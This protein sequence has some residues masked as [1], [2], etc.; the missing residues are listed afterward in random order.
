MKSY[1]SFLSVLR[2]LHGLDFSAFSWFKHSII[3]RLLQSIMCDRHISQDPLHQ[4]PQNHTSAGFRRLIRLLQSR[5]R[6]LLI[7]NQALRAQKYALNTEVSN[8]HLVLALQQRLVT[9]GENHIRLLECPNE[10]TQCP[11]GNIAVAESL[12]PLVNATNPPVDIRTGS[13]IE[14]ISPSQCTEEMDDNNT[15]MPKADRD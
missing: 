14:T 13:L 8:K 3:T 6:R 11:L 2:Y 10:D 5:K 12:Q 15:V 9:L 7:E 1:S 4:C